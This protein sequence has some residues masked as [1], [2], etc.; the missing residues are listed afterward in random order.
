MGGQQPDS[1]EQ[2]CL[3][4]CPAGVVPMEVLGS[5]G[6][7]LEGARNACLRSAG[8]FGGRFGCCVWSRTRRYSFRVPRGGVWLWVSSNEPGDG[9]ARVDV[10]LARG[11]WE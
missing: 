4:I 8:R 3:E 2:K 9:E 11:S 10:A 1:W 7:S 6:S 5:A